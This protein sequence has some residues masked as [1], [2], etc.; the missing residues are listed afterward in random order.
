MKRDALEFVYEQAAEKTF[1]SEILTSAELPGMPSTMF[2]K[3]DADGTME[4]ESFPMGP[5]AHKAKDI[6]TL[7]KVAHDRGVNS[8]EIWCA[9]NEVKLIFDPNKRDEIKVTYTTTEP[10]ELLQYWA[11]MAQGVALTQPELIQIL[12]TK[13]AGCY[14]AHAG[15]LT[16]VR[17]VNTKRLQDSNSDQQRTKVSI[18][19]SVI[20]EATGLD[21]LPEALNLDVPIHQERKYRTSVQCAFEFDVQIEKF[22]IFVLPGEIVTA[23]LE[24][25]GNIKNEIEDAMKNLDVE[26]PIYHG[27]A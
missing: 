16:T 14:D 22:K 10:F 25:D 1:R 5:D 4:F 19:R 11:K 20:N 21:A 18:S 13:L 2:A 26:Y 6:E 7:V 9:G 15:L 17:N 24:A 8:P 23:Q 12:R 27:Q 3:R